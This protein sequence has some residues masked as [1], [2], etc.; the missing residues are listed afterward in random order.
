MHCAHHR[1]PATVTILLALLAAAACRTGVWEAQSSAGT[2]APAKGNAEAPADIDPVTRALGRL[3]PA[4]LAAVR[5]AHPDKAALVS[6]FS[7]Y[8]ALAMVEG[9]A[10]GATREELRRALFIAD[11]QPAETDQAYA[12]LMTRLLARRKPA[13]DERSAVDVRVA[14]AI[15]L[16]EAT[17][18]SEAF[19]QRN[20]DFY[21]ANIAS[22]DLQ[23]PGMAD[24]I[25]G[26][27]HDATE[28]RIGPLVHEISPEVMAI[29]ANAVYLKAPWDEPFE[30]GMTN[31]R[32]FHRAD[33]STV[34]VP[35]MQTTLARANYRASETFEAV[36]LNFGS[37]AGDMTIY[38]PRDGQEPDDV[39]AAL[40]EER[41]TGGSAA[42]EQPLVR[43]SLPR[44]RVEWLG[45]LGDRLEA[46][47]IRRAFDPMQADFGDL[48]VGPDPMWIS[49][50]VHGAFA[51]VDETGLEA[52]A[53][54]VVI[55]SGAM[56][57]DEP[58]PVLVVDV[59][60]P[61]VF[62]IELAGASLFLGV[63]EDPGVLAP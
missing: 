36:R 22:Q 2:T 4:L 28:G 59:D 42:W 49:D 39:V 29:L 15:W 33:G 53:A 46:L 50:V 31:D 45:S 51:D 62:E 9:G 32:P 18:P 41:R 14:N 27:I 8:A 63:V 20:R 3:G 19:L 6:P 25:N 60:R 40:A 26:W 34:E 13:D 7:V 43:L 5:G 57:P 52:T 37:G 12:D 24:V 44:F 54:T 23:A 48:H 21:A 55:M 11:A 30:A 10:R 38:R 17:T 35:T 16:D 61:F 58:P 47:G 1:V 56:A